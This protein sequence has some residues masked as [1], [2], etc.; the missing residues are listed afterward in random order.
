MF[1]CMM[2]MC[3]MYEICMCVCVC[4]RYVCLYVIFVGTCVCHN[5]CRAQ[6]LV[7]SHL[8]ACLRW[9]LWFTAVSVGLIGPQRLL[10]LLLPFT[11]PQEQEDYRCTL[12]GLALMGSGALN[13]GL[14]LRQHLPIELLP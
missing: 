10:F 9:S 7:S 14:V 13:S 2:Y 6:P 12:P 4:N 11:L 1:L 3:D 5:M 8:P